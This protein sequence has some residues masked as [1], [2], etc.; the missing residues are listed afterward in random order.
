MTENQK[1][2]V[3]DSSRRDFLKTSSAAVVGG[4]VLAGLAVPRAVH[5]AGDDLIRIG[6]IG[7]GGRGASAARNA[8]ATKGAVKLVAVGDAFKFRLD[9]SVQQL[10]KTFADR[11][12]CPKERQFVGLDAYQKV[13]DSGVDLVILTTPPGF[14]PLHLQY[15]INAGK[16]VFMEK[17]V[18]VDAPGVRAVLDATRKA[19]DKGLGLG[20]GLQRHHSKSYIETIDRLR[21]GAIGDIHTMRAYWNGTTP[22]VRKRG[23]SPAEVKTEMQYQVNNWYFFNWLSGDHICEQHIH[24]L[25]VIN[26]LKNAYPTSAQG[27]GGREVRKG[28]DVGEIYD[29]HAVEFEYADG[30]RMFS[31]CRH[32]SGCW[33]KVAEFAQ[34]SKGN[35]DISGAKIVAEGKDGKDEWKYR[36]EP[37]DAYQTEHDDLFESIRKGQP[38]N[39]GEFG[40]LSS[41]TAVLGR[42]ATYS[43]KLVKWEDA[44]HSPIKL[45]PKE[46]NYTWETTPPVPEVAIP[47]V[48][49][50]VGKPV[51]RTA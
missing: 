5:A 26:W 11:V 3:V 41:M 10:Q 48:T 36:G 14:R 28:D 1:I 40:A 24:N 37:N 46:D 50:P 42:M 30:S 35:A 29:H 22:W 20:V 7:A 2:F 9:S 47:G 38:L 23:E 33:E 34:G 18:A 39:E 6:L 45:G 8:L 15:A 43:G 13:I 51:N 32:M 21:E 12:D 19:K 27:M 49:D 25:D 31:F 17:P 4:A 16:H 44:I